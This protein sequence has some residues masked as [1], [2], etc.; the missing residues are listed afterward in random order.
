MFFCSVGSAR[1][2][3]D[4]N[5][6]LEASPTKRIW[7]F[8]GRWELPEGRRGEPRRGNRVSV[9]IG[10]WLCPSE[11]RRA[12]LCR[13]CRGGTIPDP[14]LAA[15]SAPQPC[16]RVLPGLLPRGR[17]GPGWPR[18]PLLLNQNQ[19]NCEC[20]NGPFS[21]R[22]Q[23]RSASCQGLDAGGRGGDGSGPPWASP[24]RPRRAMWAISAGCGVSRS[25]HFLLL[26]PVGKRQWV[27]GPGP[28]M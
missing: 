26:F 20:F 27:A 15:P 22:G 8:K 1:K 3:C 7:A 23:A 2:R 9:L 17:Q 10:C 13:C 6:Y 16:G 11:R 18:H 28:S 14:V 19:T 12:E 24:P 21:S 5:T 25:F 4:R